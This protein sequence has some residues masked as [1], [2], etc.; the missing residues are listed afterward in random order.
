MLSSDKCLG[1]FNKLVPKPV[2][3]LKKLP[4]L[5]LVTY[6]TIRFQTQ[7]V[8]QVGYVGCKTSLKIM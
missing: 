3:L 2:Q 4:L 8:I 7:L 5:V 6:G 1:Y